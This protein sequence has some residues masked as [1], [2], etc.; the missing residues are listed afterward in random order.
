MADSDRR[1]KLPAIRALHHDG[2]AYHRRNGDGY[3]NATLM[4]QNNGKRW[5]DYARLSATKAFIAELEGST[6]IPVD[7]LIQE[8]TTGPNHLRGTWVH[9]RVAIDLAQWISVALK[10]AVNGWVT[11]KLLGKDP[12]LAELRNASIQNR[13]THVDVLIAHDC[14]PGR[15]IAVVTN[16]GY[17]G[18]HQKTAA[19][20]KQELGLPKTANL[21][22]NLSG[23]DLA[24][25]YLY[26]SIAA[27]N[28]EAKD[29]SGP[30]E[31]GDE[32]HAAGRAMRHFISTQ[33]SISPKKTD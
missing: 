29:L 7:L 18:Y 13:K 28:I 32:T 12:K 3:F 5:F 31:C 6:G 26:E 14:K 21:R 2:K 8:I 33:K 15:D 24:A 1:R 25:V 16:K 10:V 9:P 30:E 11:E 4:C 23:E 27:S 22:D 19:G 17:I 20:W